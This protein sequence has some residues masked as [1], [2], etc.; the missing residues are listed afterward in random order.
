MATRFLQLG[1]GK[2]KEGTILERMDCQALIDVATPILSTL[3]TAQLRLPRYK[4]LR[5]AYAY[6]I[7]F[8]LPLTQAR[9]HLG[10]AFR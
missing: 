10:A 6:A 5:Q 8:H 1:Q 3:T 2:R 7:S 9:P 4:R